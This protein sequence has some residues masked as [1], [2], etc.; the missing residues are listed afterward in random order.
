M[1]SIPSNL[2]FGDR[3]PSFGMSGN[4]SFGT[5]ALQ[6]QPT[7]QGVGGTSQ[8]QQLP[9]V[10]PPITS[11]IQNNVATGPSS[12]PDNQVSIYKNA[13]VVVFWEK[14]SLA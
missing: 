6:Q 4:Q 9:D 11:F 3:L 13:H 2:G 8:P 12:Q 5:S 14:S 7:I 10:K 1:V